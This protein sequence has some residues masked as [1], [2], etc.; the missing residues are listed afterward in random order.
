LRER[1]KEETPVFLPS[2]GVNGSWSEFE[3]EEEEKVRG[4]R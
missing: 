4:N 3:V 1:R 2:K